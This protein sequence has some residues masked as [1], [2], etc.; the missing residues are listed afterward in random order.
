[1]YA[2]KS[3]TPS[4]KPA[5]ITGGASFAS[6]GGRG[7]FMARPPGGLAAIL[8]ARTRRGRRRGVHITQAESDPGLVEIVRAHLHFDGVAG[9]DLDEMLA[10]LARDVGQHDMTV[11]QLHA[12]HRSREYGDDLAF[13]FDRFAVRHRSG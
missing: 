6:T 7:F 11:G 3:S 13:D 9:G 12:K 1:M 10:E 4:A 5:A 2:R 8:A